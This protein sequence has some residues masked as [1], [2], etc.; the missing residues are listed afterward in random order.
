MA[1]P[2]VSGAA[3]MILEQN[4]TFTPAQVRSALVD[5]ATTGALSNLGG[6]PNRLL[7]IDGNTFA[8]VEST[9]PFFVDVEWMASEGIST[10]TPG[11]PKPSYLPASAVSRQAM[12]AFMYRL[13]GEPVFSDPIDP[14][15][16]DVSTGHPF[17]TEIEWMASEGI[18]TGTPASPKPL[19]K[20]SDAVSRQAMSAFMHRLAGS[21]PFDPLGETTFLDVSTGHPFYTEIE[22]MASE[23]I[24]TGT[25]G[26]P[27][28]SYL[29][30]N[31]V[32]RQAMSAFMHR[33][34]DGPGVGV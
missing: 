21:P 23:G 2:A 16:G 27:K 8:D 3:A 10:G 19:Y 4:P 29:P 30:A 28:P 20:P 17:Y 22:W 11:S 33:L 13:A 24:T 15:F 34:A 18:T 25:P 6:T 32:S 1:A 31:A 7:W 12:S 9:N 26:S 14:T 5:Q